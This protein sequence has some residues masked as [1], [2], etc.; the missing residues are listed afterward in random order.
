[1]KSIVFTNIMY[2]VIGT[3]RHVIATDTRA[4]LLA[5][6]HGD[7]KAPP[8]AVLTGFGVS[9]ADF[10]FRVEALRLSYLF[11][12]AT[13]ELRVPGVPTMRLD[14]ERTD[15]GMNIEITEFENP[16]QGVV[17]DFIAERTTR[18]AL[19]PNILV[20]VAMKPEIALAFLRKVE[21]GRGLLPENLTPPRPGFENGID[22][23][24]GARK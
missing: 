15:D 11:D 9:C 14:R 13:R 18:Y 1:M 2:A 10:L 7:P 12:P 6:V 8:R 19:S 20:P 4:L 21:E 17:A 3:G 5:H 22:E 23:R 16:A 24:T